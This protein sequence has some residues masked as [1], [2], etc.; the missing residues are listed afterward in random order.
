[1]SVEEILGEATKLEKEFEWLQA[2]ELYDKWPDRLYNLRALLQA[3]DGR[4]PLWQNVREHLWATKPQDDGRRYIWSTAPTVADCLRSIAGAAHDFEPSEDGAIGAAIGSRQSNPFTEY[5]RAFGTGLLE[6][7]IPLTSTVQKA[8][9]IT[10]NVVLNDP[11]RDVSY[12]DVK[13]A[14]EQAGITRSQNP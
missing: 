8:M 9:A 13:Q 10:V 14:L 7:Q 12:K 11:E 2:S 5:I 3:T 1:M 4:D 6:N